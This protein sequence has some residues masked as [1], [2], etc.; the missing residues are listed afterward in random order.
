[1]LP[2]VKSKHPGLQNHIYDAEM[3]LLGKPARGRDHYYAKWRTSGLY[4]NP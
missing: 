4:I 3:K 1:M 2:I